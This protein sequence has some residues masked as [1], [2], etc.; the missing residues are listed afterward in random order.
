MGGNVCAKAR[1][2]NTMLVQGGILGDNNIVAI[3]KEVRKLQKVDGVGS[4]V[5]TGKLC[6]QNPYA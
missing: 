5:I 3:E 4:L 1:G 2:I 6:S